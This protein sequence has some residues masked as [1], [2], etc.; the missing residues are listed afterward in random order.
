MSKEKKDKK[1]EEYEVKEDEK[2]RNEEAKRD[3][4]A[5]GR[6]PY[7]VVSEHRMIEYN[8]RG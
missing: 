7:Q 1:K 8:G 5:K 4:R 3:S 2:K 6:G